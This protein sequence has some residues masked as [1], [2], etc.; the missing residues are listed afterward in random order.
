[1]YY[2]ASVIPGRKYGPVV[3]FFTGY[4]NFFA[5]LFACASLASIFT[6]QV[7]QVCI[8]DWNF[9]RYTPWEAANSTDITADVFAISPEFGF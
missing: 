6:N 2:W 9:F 1:V 4:W 3:G 5:W 8:Q 7:L